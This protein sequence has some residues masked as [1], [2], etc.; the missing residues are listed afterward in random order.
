MKKGGAS[1]SRPLVAV[2]QSA[3]LLGQAVQGAPI[4]P[5]QLKKGPAFGRVC[6]PQGPSSQVVVPLVKAVQLSS[7]RQTSR[8]PTVVWSEFPV[9]NSKCS[10]SLQS[11]TMAGIRSWSCLKPNTNQHGPPTGPL[12][13]AAAGSGVEVTVGLGVGVFFDVV[14]DVVFE[15][16]LLLLSF[17]DEVLTLLSFDDEVLTLLSFELL[18]STEA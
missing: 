2:R 11:P 13:G 17:D 5:S 4:L 7:F 16:V 12:G 18:A 8:P 15:D 9:D 6:R 1:S 14:F 10:V 3:D